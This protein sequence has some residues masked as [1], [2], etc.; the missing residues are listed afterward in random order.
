MSRPA[1]GVYGP[2]QPSRPRD[3]G[4]GLRTRVEELEQGLRRASARADAEAEA[5]APASMV[6]TH[7]ELEVRHALAGHTTPAFGCHC[8]PCHHALGGDL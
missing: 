5:G 2:E 6:A 4:N 1:P 3:L 7:V 8:T